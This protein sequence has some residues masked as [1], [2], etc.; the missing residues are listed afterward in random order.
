VRPPP[1]H[2]TTAR[3]ARPSDAF[4]NQ[5]EAGLR[6]KCSCYEDPLSE[7]SGRHRRNRSRNAGLRTQPRVAKRVCRSPRNP[8]QSYNRCSC[9]NDDPEILHF[10]V[11]AHQSHPARPIFVAHT[12][13]HGLLRA[14]EQFGRVGKD[15]G[16]D[17]AEFS[18]SG[19]VSP[20]NALARIWRDYL[21]HRRG[22]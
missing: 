13:S 22:I 17:D 3:I 10:T 6:P 11:E 21:A 4:E 2:A 14:I 20:F 19:Q 12:W 16:D 5:A 9:N 15:C 1:S 8:S 7:Y 18:A